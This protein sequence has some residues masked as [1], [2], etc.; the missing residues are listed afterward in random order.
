MQYVKPQLSELGTV[1]EL[2]LNQG[3][4]KGVPGGGSSNAN[5]NENHSGKTLGSGDGLSENGWNSIGYS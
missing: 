1:H 5:P 4:G 2:T 3:K